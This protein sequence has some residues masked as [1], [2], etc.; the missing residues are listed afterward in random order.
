MA[1]VKGSLLLTA[2]GMEIAH[3]AASGQDEAVNAFFVMKAEAER[4]HD[5]FYS[6]PDLYTHQFSYGD[7]YTGFMYR[8]WPDFHADAILSHITQAT[9]QLI[10]SFSQCPKLGSVTSEA[11]FATKEY[12]H[13]HSGFCNVQGFSDFVQ[14]E[15][16][17]EEWHRCWYAGHQTEVDWSETGND[18]LPRQDLILDILRREIKR[19]YLADYDNEEAE[20]LFNQ[21]TDADMVHVFHREV[22]GHKGDGKEGY[23]SAIGGEICR[24]NYYIYEAELS[25]MERQYAKSM[26]E[27]YSIINKE[28][29]LQFIS[30]D[31]GHGMFEFHD[32][33]GE[34]QGEFRFDGS[35]NSGIETDHRLKSIEQWRK[36]TGR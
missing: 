11:D 16:D 36:Q 27:I 30:I 24:C 26:R 35:P 7:F 29:K 33:N 12:P 3:V 8:A 15:D 21:I 9:H 2:E 25:D 34:H 18:W 6:L 22:M 23:A 28:G 5:R 31:F 20:R 32:E 13:A 1:K 19:K 4:R 17:W 14:S 10:Q